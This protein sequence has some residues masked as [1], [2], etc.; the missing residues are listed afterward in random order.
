MQ[1]KVIKYISNSTNLQI[2]YV[3]SILSMY[4][5]CKIQNILEHITTASYLP[6]D[7]DRQRTTI[8]QHIISDTIKFSYFI[9]SSQYLNMVKCMVNSSINSSDYI[10]LCIIFNFQNIL[11]VHFWKY[12]LLHPICQTIT[13]DDTRHWLTIF[14][15][16]KHYKFMINS[17]IIPSG[18]IN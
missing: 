13:P 18:Y 11:N 5:V 9:N 1:S 4:V 6:A 7:R 12:K 10:D 3:P 8:F 15:A 17:T 2:N 14:E 16:I